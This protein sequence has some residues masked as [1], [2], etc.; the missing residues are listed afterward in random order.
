LGPFRE[1]VAVT[2]I[3]LAVLAIAVAPGPVRSVEVDPTEARIRGGD[4]T[5]Q[6]VV[7][8]V[9]EGDRRVD[10]THTQGT[11]FESLDPGVATV[12]DDGLVH[13]VGDGSARVVVHAGAHTAT[14]RI[15]VR[16]FANQRP[17]H[18]ESEVVPILTKLGCNSGVCHGKASGQNGFRLSLLGFNPQFDYESVARDSRGRRV[19]PAAP[20]SSLM[21]LK[22]TAGVPHGGGKKFAVGSP[23]YRTI[24]RWIAQGMPLKS[25]PESQLVSVAVSPARRVMA[26]RSEQQLRVTA[27]YA[28]GTTAD[29]TRLAQYQSN[30]G[31]L[32]SVDGTG[33]VSA[34]DGVGEAAIMARFGGQVGVARA[35]IPLGVDLPPWETPPSRN[36]VDRHVFGKL[37]ELGLPPS[38]TCTDSEFARRSSL[39]IC[40]VLPAPDEVK[41]FEK[42][43]DPDKRAKWVA[44][45]VDRPEYADLFAMKW[46]AILKN[47]RNLGAP[48]QAGTFAFH[49]WIRQSLAEDKPYNKFVAEIL[50]A[51]GD[52]M[53]NPPVVWY[54]QEN[55]VEEQVDDTAQ[56]FLGMRIQCSR[57]HHH[58]FERWSPD[59]YYG[60]AAIFSR[61]GRKNG[62]D[63]VTPRIYLLAQGTATDPTTQKR[64]NPRVLGGQELKDLGPNQDPRRELANWLGDPDNPYF[65]K[66]LVNRYWKHFL[67]R[68]LVEPED[69]MR[70]S[71]PPSNPELLEALADDFVKHGYRL[72]HL[73]Q[74]IATSRAYDRSSLPNE[75][76][77]ND[78]QN[79]ARFY[80]RRLPAEVLLDA[81][82]VA[83]GSP[84][85]FNGLPRSF[86]ATQL[87]DEGFD[88]GAQF[89]EVF[90]RPK[91]ES[92]CECERISEANLAQSLHLLN[93]SEIERK[94]DDRQSRAA[95]LVA[96]K[97]PDAEK[98]DDLYRMCYSRSP[99]A[100]ELE[101]CL[102]HLK[103]RRGE[104]KLRQG[105]EDL[106]WT[107]LNTKEF[108]F[109]Q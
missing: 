28:D 65:A 105:Y 26:R 68:G 4:N 60:F 55:M 85:A 45:L 88:S 47:K 20:A 10:L 31:D 58:P 27:T 108:V 86:R 2:L 54:R 49:A 6:I 104:D 3:Q 59:D 40:G 66:A 30:A 1:G 25:G 62:G 73:V 101:V 61:I 53:V 89:L 29:V 46:S 93:S 106:I 5:A 37:R 51:R 78:R 94:L 36:F 81:V 82:S 103:R 56:L 71:N 83:T 18:F 64:Y 12:D 21:L 15:T 23:E 52:P 100:D 102:A 72:K 17:V 97:R 70:V 19:F 11:R 34:L 41:R 42:A 98:V 43:T 13:P 32:A 87:P 44:R 91:R 80:P 76:N 33:R 9:G 77:A 7:T 84:E 57:C 109:N 50:T 75:W 8:G 96:D 90:G 74:T 107:L 24:A 38:E 14:V 22:P 63:A 95:Q 39:D 92:V 48:S 67:G 79:F 99:T 16:D 35:T 69:D